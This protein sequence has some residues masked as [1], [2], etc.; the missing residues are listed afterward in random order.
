MKLLTEN[1]IK[2][3]KIG[4]RDHLQMKLKRHLPRPRTTF[5]LHDLGNNNELIDNPNIMGHFKMESVGI[6]TKIK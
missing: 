4:I 3:I 6:I 2:M 1:Y 5:T